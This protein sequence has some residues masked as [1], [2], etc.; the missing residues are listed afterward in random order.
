MIL[1]LV[2][3]QVMAAREQTRVAFHTLGCKVNQYEADKLATHFSR[4]GY[5]LCPSGQEADVYVVNTC[6]VTSEADR[7]SRQMIRRMARRNPRSLVV[8]TGCHAAAWSDALEGVRV[9][10]IG[11]L[12][13]ETVFQQVEQALFGASPQMPDHLD[14]HTTPALLGRT[15]SYLKIQD[16]CDRF[17]TYC[18]I[19]YVR[20]RSRSRPVREILEEA[21]QL[22]N[23][24]VQ[25]IVVT[26]ICV[27]DY[28]RDFQPRETLSGLI[29]RLLAVPYLGRFRLSSFDP[30]DV[31]EN[32]VELLTRH[33]RF[34]RHLHLALQHGSDR[35]LRR[36][37]REYTRQE[38]F[39]LCGE[40]KRRA[41]GFAVTT[42]VI[43]GFPGETDE[44]FQETVNLARAVG[45]SK[46]HVF[47]YSERQGT[48]AVK[49]RHK[50]HAQLRQQRVD[51]LLSVSRELSGKFH[52]SLLGTTSGVL[53][54]HERDRK[55]GFLQGYTSNYVPTLFSGPDSWTGKMIPVRLLSLYGEK[56]IGSA[57]MREASLEHFSSRKDFCVDY[58]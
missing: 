36:M 49:H 26:G 10:K 22:M 54:E 50:V 13:K 27:G 45:F 12:E 16:G 14:Y 28:G 40:L 9:L 52:E 7:K 17:C 53:V 23:A 21:K 56:V 39:L 38:F 33:P 3:M 25:E 24:G 48:G 47:P 29:E 31:D 19:P 11:Q 15:R 8:V 20:G 37:G 43:V 30:C 6:T 32:L 51:H 55:T 34:C 42:D 57:D 44:D 4:A 18:I 35:I 46:I 2:E 1:T 5:L 41:S 58:P